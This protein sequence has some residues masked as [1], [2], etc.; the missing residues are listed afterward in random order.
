MT[1]DTETVPYWG[2]AC[3]EILINVIINSKNLIDKEIYSKKSFGEKGSINT[4]LTL[5]FLTSFAS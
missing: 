3:V 4:D 5:Y 1:F 2:L